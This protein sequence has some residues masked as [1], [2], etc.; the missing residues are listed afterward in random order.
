MT[1]WIAQCVCPSRHCIAA[2]YAEADGP[3]AAEREVRRPLVTAVCLAL[4]AGEVNPWCG[5]C[6]AA[7][8][9]WNY[10]LARSRF[11]TMAEAEPEMK[12][13]AAEQAKVRR[14][15]GEGETRH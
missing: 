13:L 14:A 4:F 5:L 7:S 2:A 11:S 10:E 3:L 8:S 15:Y 12:R 6:G 1:V 9:A